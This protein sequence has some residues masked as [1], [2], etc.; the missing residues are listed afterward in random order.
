M[1]SYRSRRLIFA[2]PAALAVAV[3]AGCGGGGS[4]AT[5]DAAPAA[6]QNVA[7]TPSA[8][9]GT[10]QQQQQRTFPG[11]SG[12]IADISGKTM[13]VQNTSSQTAVTYTDATT[14]TDTVTATR[15][16]LKVGDCVQVRDAADTA[17]SA[18]GTA[19]DATAAIT[20]ATVA[21]SDAVD[22][23]CSAAGGFG[24]GFG[25][26]RPDGAQGAPAQG[27]PGGAAGDGAQR[28]F[29]GGGG[30]FGKVTAIDGDTVTVESSRPAGMPGDSTGTAAQ[31]TTRAVTL[32]TGTTYTKTVKATT[33]AL[34]VGSCVTALGTANDSGAITASSITIRPAVD[35]TCTAA[36]FGRPGGGTGQDR[37]NTT[38]ASNG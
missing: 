27:A 29:R 31:S 8:G 20:A 9:T 2:A 22:G 28:A 34:K 26:Q 4:N 18:T 37:N 5:T 33:S 24:G 38:G 17:T 6:A 21:I 25:G 32:A 10:N 11:A 13:Q 23:A 14:V 30:A 15:A 7:P 1:T 19:P 16:D 35:G 12:Q 3:L 36:T